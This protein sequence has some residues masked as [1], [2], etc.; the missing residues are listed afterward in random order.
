MGLAEEL[1]TQEKAVREWLDA[2]KKQVA[3]VQK[4]QKATE[5]GSVRDLE[6]LRQAAQASAEALAER[7]RA[8]PELAFDASAYLQGEGGFLE[9]LLAEAERIGLTLYERDGTIFSYP[10]LVRREPDLAAVRVDKVLHFTLRPSVLAAILKKLQQ[11]D[12]KARP[13]RFVE[14]LF[15][16]Y[17]LLRAKEGVQSWI[18]LPLAQ[19]Y[20]VLT[21]LPGSEKDY[22]LLDFTR[23][24]YFLD[25]SGITQTK[26]GYELSLPAST[27]SRERKAK[28]LPFVDRQGRE[29]LYATVKFTPQGA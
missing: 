19:V 15:T 23:D 3:A 13:E 2:A 26:K 11:R 14:T 5:L 8:C 12:A 7:A 27:A 17:E 10:V 4:L 25:T 29:K 24:I 18:D 28:L 6:K 22:T 21:L 9:E 20:D 16:A 1:S